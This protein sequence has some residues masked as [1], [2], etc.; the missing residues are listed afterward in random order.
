MTFIDKTIAAASILSGGKNKTWKNKCKKKLP[1]DSVVF[2]F[3]LF[4]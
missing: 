1:I 4:Y 3:V 2:Y